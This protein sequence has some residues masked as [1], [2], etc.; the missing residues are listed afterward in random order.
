V[1]KKKENLTRAG[2]I[3]G[4]DRAAKFAAATAAGRPRVRGVRALH[5][6]EKVT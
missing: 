2:G 4:G 3:R 6:E 1:K 5:E